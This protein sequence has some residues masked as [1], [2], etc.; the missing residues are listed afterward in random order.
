M[1]S[2][3][4]KVERSRNLSSVNKSLRDLLSNFPDVNGN[5]SYL[6]YFM[7][8]PSLVFDLKVLRTRNQNVVLGYSFTDK[9]LNI[10]H[11]Y[12]L[13][14]LNQSAKFATKL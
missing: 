14:N 9:L 13:A 3:R 6:R 2:P 10:K 11:I 5:H 12:L 1:A 4:Y 8:Y 7:T